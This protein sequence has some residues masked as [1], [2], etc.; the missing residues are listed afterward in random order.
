MQEAVK[1]LLNNLTELTAY[2]SKTERNTLAGIIKNNLIERKPAK[3]QNGKLRHFDCSTTIN[4]K[5]I[6]IEVNILETRYR[7]TTAWF[8]LVDILN[9]KYVSITI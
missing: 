1:Y 5:R 3:V 9:Q 7:K 2:L 6:S 8:T 4:S